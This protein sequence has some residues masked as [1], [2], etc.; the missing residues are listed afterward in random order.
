MEDDDRVMLSAEAILEEAYARR[1]ISL[2]D[3]GGTMG[4]RPYS[5]GI[6]RRN[7]IASREAET[8]DFCPP[9]LKFGR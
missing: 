1:S 2:D 7:K 4:D 3:L 5:D 8:G 9:T 6:A